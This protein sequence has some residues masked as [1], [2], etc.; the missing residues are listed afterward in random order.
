[1]QV[2]LDKRISDGFSV[3]AALHVLEDAFDNSSENKQTRRDGDQP[4]GLI[5][6]D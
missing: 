6:F 1:M 4:G 5:E 3:C 2:T